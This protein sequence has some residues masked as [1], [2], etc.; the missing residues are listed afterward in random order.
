MPTAVVAIGGNSLVPAN[1]RGS[2]DEQ[3]EALRVT[4]EG[5]AD[6]VACG[7]HVVVTHGNGPQVGDAWR[8]SELAAVE[9]EPLPLDVCVAETQGS[10]GYLLQQTLEDELR[11]RHGA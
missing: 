10:I 7:Y 6:V 4:S 5:I 2:L 11:R 3:R 1:G 9:V 8:R